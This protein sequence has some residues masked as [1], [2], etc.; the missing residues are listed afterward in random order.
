[1]LGLNYEIRPFLPP[2]L[3]QR[4]TRSFI[5]SITMDRIG[6]GGYGFVISSGKC[7]RKSLSICCSAPKLVR[8][9]SLD[10]HVIKQN[11]I[12]FVQKLRNLLLSKPKHYMSIHVLSKCRSYLSLSK[13]R[14]ILSMI[15]R[16]PTLFELFYVPYPP[17]PLN[18][19][20]TNSQLC[21]RLTPAAES[22]SLREAHLKSTASVVMANKLQKLLMLSPHRRLV[23]SKLAHLGPDL[24]LPP[25]FRSRLCNENPGKFKIVTTSYGNALELVSWDPNLAE[26]LPKFRNH[27]PELIVDRPL[28]FKLVKLRKGLTVKRRHHDFLIRFGELPDICPYKT[29]F[30][31]FHKS[32]LE[33]EKRACSVVREILGMTVEKRTLIDHLTHFRKDF[34]LPNKLRA[35]LVRHPE[36]FYVSLKG[37]RD[38]V[39]LVEAYDDN[40]E[41]VQKDEG[42]LIKNHLFELVRHGKRIRRE[43]KLAL[44]NGDTLIKDHPIAVDQELEPFDDVTEDDGFEELF[45]GN[46]SEFEIYEE[47]S[48]EEYGQPV[49]DNAEQQFWSSHGSIRG[50]REDSDTSERW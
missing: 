50:H 31:E 21:V 34:G 2:A 11:R 24:G 9:R 41:L 14:C 20:K 5:P 13:P 33:A 47:D 25:N 12:R 4:R 3:D 15:E 36:L 18:A 44:A 7:K 40:G 32:S 46:D 43:M 42:L 48:D 16:Y 22:L 10:R 45:D 17:T 28:K 39:F 8:D 23:M 35:M 6:R 26:P 38:T 19:T 37:Q 49:D 30:K 27:S 1:M 29:S